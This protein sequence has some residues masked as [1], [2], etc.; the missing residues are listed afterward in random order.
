MHAPFVCGSLFY[1]MQTPER[2]LIGR[3]GGVFG[4]HGELKVEI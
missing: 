1:A 3:V 2:L 4:V